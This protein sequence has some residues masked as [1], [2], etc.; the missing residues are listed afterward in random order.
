MGL[1]YGGEGAWATGGGDWYSR[2][3]GV[4]V[5][6]RP[7]GKSCESMPYIPYMNGISGL[8]ELAE[9]DGEC[10]V[11]T[12]AHDTHRDKG[13]DEMDGQRAQL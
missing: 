13:D 1:F 3:K 4:T 7:M 6:G 5:V 10:G 9:W 2:I 11:V 12:D 8:L